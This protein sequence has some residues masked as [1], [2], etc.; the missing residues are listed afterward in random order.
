M[1]KKE[2]SW[3]FL[4]IQEEK[5][6]QIIRDVNNFKLEHLKPFSHESYAQVHAWSFD[7][8]KKAEEAKKIILENCPNARDKF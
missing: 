3:L 7:D 1:A 2:K 5:D 8:P 4:R 6:E